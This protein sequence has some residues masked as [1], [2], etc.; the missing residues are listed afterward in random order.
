MGNHVST[1]FK[2]S[3]N[4]GLHQVKWNGTNNN[5][6][7]LSSGLYFYKLTSGNFTQTRKLLFAK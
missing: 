2:G 7:I 4:P 1:L 3:L 5:G 6:Q